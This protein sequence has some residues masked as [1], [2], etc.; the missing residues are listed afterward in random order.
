MQNEQYRGEWFGSL[1]KLAGHG[2]PEEGPEFDYFVHVPV[3]LRSI[4][5]SLPVD[6]T[7]YT[8]QTK[9]KSL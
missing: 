8:F 1:Y 4:I 2:D 3:F 5:V 9:P 7:H 6:C